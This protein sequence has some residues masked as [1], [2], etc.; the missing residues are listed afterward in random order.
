MQREEEAEDKHMA[1]SSEEEEE[2]EDE[3]SDMDD[4]PSD[5]VL[6]ALM[7]AEAALQASPTSYRAHLKV[8]FPRSTRAALR[9]ARRE[10]T[11]RRHAAALARAAAHC[12]PIP[13][14]ALR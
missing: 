6:T 3:D 8:G 7:D 4:G 13:A 10:C 2:E 1:G 5:D 14:G 11:C 12:P 9:S